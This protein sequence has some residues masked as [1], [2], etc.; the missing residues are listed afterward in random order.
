MLIL[1]LAVASFLAY[2]CIVALLCL[3]DSLETRTRRAQPVIQRVD[4]FATLNIAQAFDPT[5]GALWEAPIRA[6]DCLSSAGATGIPISR[7]YPI[8]REAASRFPEI[9][10]GYHFQEWL[11]FLESNELI[12]WC[13]QQ[14]TLTRQG[15][16]FLA[17][18]FTTE[19]LA[20]A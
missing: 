15:R 16:E 4:P 18:R 1:G 11:Q 20:R 6:L 2:I 13:G 10:D 8:F 9:Y 14:V 19:P 5:Y 12:H 17:H 3:A 7:L